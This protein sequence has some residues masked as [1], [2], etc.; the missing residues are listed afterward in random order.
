MTADELRDVAE[1]KQRIR[2]ILLVLRTMAVRV[3]AR[4]SEESAL[5]LHGRIGAIGRGLLA[6]VA[7]GGMDL[8]SLVLDELLLHA[9]GREQISVRGAGVR[10]SAKSAELMSLVLHELAT[11]AVKFGALCGSQARVMIRWWIND[12]TEPR[13]LHFE[14]QETG[15]PLIAG[16]PH[17]VGFGCELVERLIASELHGE[18]RM[19]FSAEG[20]RCIINIP[21]AEALYPELRDNNNV[22]ARADHHE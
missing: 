7:S 12:R 21:A 4:S 2:R 15:V 8:E 20:V 1:L 17:R 10:L 16:A 18:G 11:N 5:H 3:G 19:I 6:P 13:Q 14:W 9:P 22:N